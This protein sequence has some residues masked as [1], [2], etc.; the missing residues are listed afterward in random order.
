MPS[1]DSAPG[2]G[3]RIGCLRR[4]VTATATLDGYPSQFRMDRYQRSR[5][6]R[7]CHSD[8]IEIEGGAE[9]EAADDTAMH[10]KRGGG[11]PLVNNFETIVQRE[12]SYLEN[13]RNFN[14]KIKSN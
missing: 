10:S 2:V 3:F 8:R 5:R 9:A 11:Q 13:S 6:R 12:I 14:N 4:D 7:R 1:H